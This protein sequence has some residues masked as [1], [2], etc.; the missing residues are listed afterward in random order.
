M[1]M[2]DQ[3]HSHV[4]SGNAFRDAWLDGAARAFFVSAYAD[5]CEEADSTDNE[6]TE[7]ERDERASLPRPGAGEDWSAYA[8][9]IPPLAYALAGELWAMLKSANNGCSVYTL[10]QSAALA[11]RVPEV[12]AA[13]FGSDL[14]MQAMG[15]GVSWFDDHARFDLQVPH[16]ECGDWT[17]SP[18][19]YTA[20]ESACAELHDI[21]TD[22]R[23]GA[24]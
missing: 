1:N 21:T 9:E 16:L 8:P 12:D 19:V 17:F 10:A 22:E 6:L 2:Q 3:D 5:H 11:D 13:E 23:G 14:A 15:H 20:G 24:S 4:G 18:D 7:E